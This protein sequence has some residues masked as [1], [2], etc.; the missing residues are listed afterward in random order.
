MGANVRDLYVECQVGYLEWATVE[1][2]VR[3]ETT[4][5]V[6]TQVFVP[7]HYDIFAAPGAANSD[8]LESTNQ[9]KEHATRAPVQRDLLGHR[10]SKG[11]AAFHEASREATIAA[12]LAGSSTRLT[13]HA[14]L[15]A[16]LIDE[17]T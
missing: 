6:Q 15:P 2:P 17:P 13:I 12:E 3:G 4:M 10:Q 14:V 1:Q 11:V 8:N 5:T 7:R 9:V 16:S